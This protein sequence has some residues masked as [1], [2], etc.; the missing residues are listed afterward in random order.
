MPLAACCTG[1]SLNTS[2]GESV[3]ACWM[4]DI[5]NYHSSAGEALVISKLPADGGKG[6]GQRNGGARKQDAGGGRSGEAAELAGMDA[7]E[8]VS[9]CAADHSVGRVGHGRGTVQRNYGASG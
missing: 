3:V 7:D 9:H 2:A 8:S 4:W 6:E 5:G 1:E